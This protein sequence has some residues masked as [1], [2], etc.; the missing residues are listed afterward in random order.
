MRNE[1]SE[2]SDLDVLVEFAEPPDLF[3]FMDLEQHLGDLLG[4]RIDLV[5]RKALR[6]R[7]G[8]HIV[9]GVIPV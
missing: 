8:Q 4:V 5:S 3:Q 9:A 6:G 1:Q 2:T 7:I